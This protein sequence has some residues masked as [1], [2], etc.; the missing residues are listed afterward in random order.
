MLKKAINVEISFTYPNV[1]FTSL[2][3]F[4]EIWAQT[5][6]MLN[7]FVAYGFFSMSKIS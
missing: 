3:V 5:V 7:G 6:L 1:G 4:Y 2:C